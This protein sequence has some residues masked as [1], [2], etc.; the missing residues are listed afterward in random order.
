MAGALQR[1]IA[2]I[3]ALVGKYAAGEPIYLNAVLTDGASAV[4]CRFTTDDPANADSL[5]TNRGR[6]YVCEDGV[7]R[8]LDPGEAN[9]SAVMVSSEPLSTDSGWESVPV[10]HLL[11]IEPDLSIARE[12]VAA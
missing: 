5:Y 6:R 8:M 3:S 1:T 9:G 4:A 11:R 10:N 2:R 7:C 12:P